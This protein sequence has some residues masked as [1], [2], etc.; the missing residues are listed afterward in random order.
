MGVDFQRFNVDGTENKDSSS[1]VVNSAAYEAT[2]AT[3]LRLHDVRRRSVEAVEEYDVNN[4]RT[5]LS[6][7][8]ARE[9][10]H[11]TSLQHVPIVA[12]P[13]SSLAAAMEGIDLPQEDERASTRAL[14]AYMRANVDTAADELRQLLAAPVV[15]GRHSRIM[16]QRLLN[17]LG[18]NGDAKFQVRRRADRASGPRRSQR[19]C[20]KF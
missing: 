13:P 12:A 6:K 2:G 18:Q 11:A 3:T 20:R 4:M 19:I 9:F 17:E 5:H 8:H 14:A 1:E 16:R 15:M 7:R 10:E